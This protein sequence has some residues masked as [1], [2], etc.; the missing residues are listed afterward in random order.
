MKFYIKFLKD[1]KKINNSD[2]T[3]MKSMEKMF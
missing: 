3:K 1:K 2:K